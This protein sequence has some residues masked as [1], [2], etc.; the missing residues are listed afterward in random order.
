MNQFKHLLR[1]H[2]LQF[3][4]ACGL[5]LT[6]LPAM[7]ADIDAP[8]SDGAWR[9]LFSPW[10]YHYRSD[11]E[12][13]SVWLVGL[14][15]EMPDR[16]LYGLAGFSNSFG[17][18][19]AYAYVGHVFNNVLDRWDSLYLTVSVGVIYGYVA[20]YQDKLSF[21]YNGFAPAIIPAL[22][23]RLDRDWNVQTNVLGSA[24]LMLMVTRRL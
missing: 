19:S 8:A 7:A 4:A 17:Q 15:R 13:R 23:W 18:P 5:V 10:T 9:V 22:G 24:G 3:V 12:Y 20:P 2:G 11:P 21:N 6:A 14:E 1:L 16:T